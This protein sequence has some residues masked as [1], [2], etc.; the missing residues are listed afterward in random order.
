[1]ENV[2][3]QEVNA[4]E[5]LEAQEKASFDIQVVTAKKFPRDIRKARDNSIVIATMNDETAKSCGYALPRAGK[6]IQ[7][8]SVHL[9]RILSQNWGNLRV[10][11]RVAE[12]TRNQV[13]SQ[14]VCFDLESNYAVKV[15][16][17]KK[18]TD[19]QGNRFNEDMITVTGNAA[20][21]IA[22]RNA[23]FS[24]IPKAVTESVYKATKDKLTGDLSDS[25]K[26]IKERAK[27]FKLFKDN[28]KATEEEVLKA[29]GLATINA[30]KQDHIILMQGFVQSLKDGD[31]T[32]DDLFDRNNKKKNQTVDGK[33][34][35]MKNGNN[36]KVDMP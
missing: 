11:A 23:V 27:L 17:R 31:T 35:N 18:I 1:M 29:I 19:K 9:A 6:S 2:Q 14:A 8:P 25:T 20:N 32:P 33:K 36:T 7:G 30:V 26:L 21:A 28:Y 4:V 13:V 34:Q 10:E 3:I 12:I 5:L 15:E 16:V 24:V 22:F